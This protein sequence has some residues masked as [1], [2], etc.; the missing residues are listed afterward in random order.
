M[1]V[2]PVTMG[3][4]I[5]AGSSLIGA[6]GGN[7]QAGAQ[8]KAA[9]QNSAFLREQAMNQ[10]VGTGPNSYQTQLQDLISGINFK[11]SSAPTYQAA[12]INPS[13]YSPNLNTGNDALMQL[14][15]K[16]ASGNA[17]PTGTA[18]LKSVV[19][20]GGN[21]FDTSKEFQALGAVDKTSTQNQIDALLAANTAGGLGARFGTGLQQKQVNLQTQ[22]AQGINARNAGI[23]Q[24]AYTDAQSR[25]G[26]AAGQ[27]NS[28]YLQGQGLALSGAQALNQGALSAA[29]INLAGAQ[30]N[31]NATNTASQANQGSTLQTTSMNNSQQNAVIQQILSA[32]MSGSGIQQQN[33]AHNL[34]V[35]QTMAGIP[36]QQVAPASQIPGAVGGIG[37]D[38]MI[39]SIL[40]SMGNKG[41]TAGGAGANG[42]YGYA[43]SEFD[44][45]AGAVNGV[46]GAIPNFAFGF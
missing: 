24:Q 17:D 21:P 31:Q 5:E 12:Q 20:G 36:G 14:I 37:Q 35:V 3:L 42:G 46:G 1:G 13:Q 33:Q 7:K 23:Q 45:G 11:P 4:G 15:T 8:T 44:Y 16:G 38:A 29:G 25:A 40:Q 32:I 6:I 10:M 39:N 30:A 43:P 26:A 28:N 18:Y 27:L 41:G 2:D 19:Q 9:N 34:S 22:I